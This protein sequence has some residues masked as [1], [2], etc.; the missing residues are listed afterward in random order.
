MGANNYRI[1]QTGVTNNRII[2]PIELDWD[3]AGQDQSIELYQDEVV[4][5][6]I[7][8]GYDFE[9]NRFPHAPDNSGSTK[10]NYEF[11]FH[12]GSSLSNSSDWN[13]NF[14]SQGITVR[15]M[16]YT[17]NYF[18]KSFFKLDFYDTVDNKRQTN[19]IT[20]IIPTQEGK[21]STV[22]LNNVPVSV[23]TPV[24]SLDYIGNKEGF[25]IYW[26]KN[27][28]FLNIN[29]FYMTA[30][31]YNAKTGQFIKMTNKPQST[32]VGDK[33][34]LDSITYFYYRVVLD[35]VDMVYRVYD[36]NPITGVNDRVGTTTP[37]KWYEY[38]NPPQ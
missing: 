7:G 21:P 28:D 16:Y 26:L 27:L 29:T 13:P 32:V 36:F 38:V 4:K 11:N 31:F 35:Y 22:L 30:K 10:I 33:Y 6:V 1:I 8:D 17:A 19:Y 24:Y 14:T 12:S 2:V 34:N 18:T 25:F 3:F 20:V 23:R 15:E 9:V 37:I 5:K